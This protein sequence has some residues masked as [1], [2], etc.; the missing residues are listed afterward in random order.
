MQLPIKQLLAAVPVKN[1]LCTVSDE[2]SVTITTPYVLK[3]S[4]FSLILF[5]TGRWGQGA[6]MGETRLLP[7]QHQIKPI[8]LIFTLDV[9]FI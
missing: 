6:A 7:E 8:I 5:N 4:C 3:C 1:V 2:S 9:L